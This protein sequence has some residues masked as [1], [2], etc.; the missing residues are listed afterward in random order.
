[1]P[2]CQSAVFFA[3]CCLSKKQEQLALSLPFPPIRTD[4]P[5]RI[6]FI[7]RLDSY[8]RL[9]WLFEALNRL[10]S[11]R[12]LVVVEDGPNRSRFER[13]DQTIFPSFTSSFSRSLVR[14]FQVRAVG[15]SRCL[16]A[17]LGL[18]Q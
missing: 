14:G 7:G 6:V 16:G 10:T 2:V 15:C 17:S 11:P 4:Q 1:M 9:D 3:P 18:L 12:H 13:L 5:L 8:K